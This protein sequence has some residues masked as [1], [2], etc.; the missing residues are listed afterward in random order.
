MEHKQYKLLWMGQALGP[1]TLEEI[2]S[3]LA[4]EDIGLSHM[5]E[6]SAGDW[7]LLENFLADL[8]EHPAEPTPI[9]PS[10]SENEAAEEAE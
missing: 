6:N 10:P 5:I 1:Y 7:I 3:L 9:N 8:K 4:K 2:K